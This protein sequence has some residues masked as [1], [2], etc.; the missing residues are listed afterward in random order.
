MNFD[1]TLID[2]DAALV[3]G[4]ASFQLLARAVQLPG[5]AFHATF[6]AAPEEDV[7]WAPAGKASRFALQFEEGRRTEDR[8]RV[9]AEA[10]GWK[11][12]PTSSFD[13]KVRRIDAA[14]SVAGFGILLLDIKGAK[15]L[16]RSDVAPQYRFHWLELH[17]TGS[18]FSG[19]S[20]VL[21]LEVG[22]GRFALFNKNDLRM[23]VKA[24]V[25]GPPVASSK[26]ALF[27]PYQRDGKL[28]EWITLVD[29]SQ[30]DSMC[31][32]VI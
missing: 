15:K 1:K 9:A 6:E 31:K 10:Q 2:S 24:N 5:L 7:G 14:F 21:A 17:D 25:K 28:R 22:P 13:D 26:Q 3:R 20:S 4:D 32:G 19:W 18:L 12:V 30:L 23:W 11:H 16:S 29:V 8:F 27:R